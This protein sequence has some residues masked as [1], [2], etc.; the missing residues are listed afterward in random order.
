MQLWRSQS[1]TWSGPT[2]LLHRRCKSKVIRCSVLRRILNRRLVSTFKKRL[3]IS[4]SVH[5][6]KHITDSVSAWA[7]AGGAGRHRQRR[8]RRR[9]RGRRHR[10]VT[11]RARRRCSASRARGTRRAPC[12][13]PPGYSRGALLALRLGPSKGSLKLLHQPRVELVI[14]VLVVLGGMRSRRRLR[15]QRGSRRP[16]RR[17][18]AV[19]ERAHSGRAAVRAERGGALA[20][21]ERRR[22]TLGPRLG[23]LAHATLLRRIAAAAAAATWVVDV[24][25][26]LHH[27]HHKRHLVDEHRFSCVLTFL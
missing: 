6:R 24:P 5:Y 20:L 14:L 22:R 26:V 12:T 19:G 18:A 27:G 9:R 16:R 21:T 13:Q 8:R 3:L 2:K 11:G 1:V 23:H 10:P 15:S 17:R 7:G 4:F 25:I